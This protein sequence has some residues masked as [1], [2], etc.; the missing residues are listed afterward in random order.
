[1]KYDKMY[2]R[3]VSMLNVG[4]YES[5]LDLFERV[6][7]MDPTVIHAVYNQAYTLQMMKRQPEAVKAYEKVLKLK[8]EHSHAWVN[9]ALCYRE[10]GDNAKAL[11]I[12]DRGLRVWPDSVDMLYNKGNVLRSLLRYA[13]SI[14]VYQRVLALRPEHAKAMWNLG[15]SYMTLGDLKNGLPLYE[16]GIEMLVDTNPV[17]SKMRAR[18]Y[19]DVPMWNK[20][21]LENKRILL[22][23]EQG[24]GDTMQCIRYVHDILKQKPAVVHVA[25]QSALKKLLQVAFDPVRHRVN[26]LE[27]GEKRVY[28][29]YQ[30]SIISLPYMLNLTDIEPCPPYLFAVSDMVK[31]YVPILGD[32]KRVGLVWSGNPEHPNDKQ[33]SIPLKTLDPLY[34]TIYPVA[35]QLDVRPEDQEVLDASPI[36]RV[37]GIKNFIDTAA[38]LKTLKLLITVDTSVAHLAG[39][40]GVP[41]WLMI[42][43][44]A[45]WRWLINRTDSPWYPTMRIFRQ[46]T[47]GDWDSVVQEIV[48]EIWKEYND[49]RSGYVEDRPFELRGVTQ[50]PTV[51]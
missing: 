24:L 25:V 33:R 13:D 10:L 26:V 43:Y 20:E 17:W 12:Y 39:A 42:P 8:P 32:K 2:N 18:Y 50:G 4:M 46:P 47:P 49:E 45:D 3:G 11:E 27:M 23:A 21:P 37:N 28:V 34:T 16:R 9:L 36:W 41:V 6:I 38:V 29:D 51:T 44:E 31:D 30:C 15:L 40:M 48:A 35:V 1:M 7:K 19:E 22:Y 14:P 5:A